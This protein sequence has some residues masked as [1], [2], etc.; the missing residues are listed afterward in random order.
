MR[1]IVSSYLY[2]CVKHTEYWCVIKCF[3]FLMSVLGEDL[4]KLHFYEEEKGDKCNVVFLLNN[5]IFFS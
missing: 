2:G 4:K 5:F 3:R 1:V